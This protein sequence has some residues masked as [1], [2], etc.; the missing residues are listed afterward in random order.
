MALLIQASWR[1]YSPSWFTFAQELQ[2]ATSVSTHS[3]ISVSLRILPLIIMSEIDMLNTLNSQTMC[4]LQGML[5]SYPGVC[6]LQTG[7]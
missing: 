6:L 4:T 5:Y 3:F 1:A 2:S 7:I